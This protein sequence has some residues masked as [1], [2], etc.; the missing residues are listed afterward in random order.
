MSPLLA[1]S[2]IATVAWT[3]PVEYTDGSPLPLTE[4]QATEVRY[5]RCT[6]GGVA[7]DAP[8]VAVPPPPAVASIPLPDGGRWCFQARTVSV[9]GVP[10]EWSSTVSREWPF[11]AGT[12]VLPTLPPGMEV[13]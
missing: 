1:L 12:P 10:S 13:R 11:D 8:F 3:H 6:D 9:E 2:I 7:D 5:G 4:I